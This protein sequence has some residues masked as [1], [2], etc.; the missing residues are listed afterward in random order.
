MVNIDGKRRRLI[1]QRGGMYGRSLICLRSSGIYINS[2]AA[3]VMDLDK[4]SNA[5]LESDDTKLWIVPNN[6]G[7]KLG[8]CR[9]RKQGLKGKNNGLQAR[10]IVCS[11][12]YSMYPS[13][14]ALLKSN[15][16]NL[17]RLPL[18][19]D[20][21]E[22]FIEIIPCF[23]NTV[24]TP[25]QLPNETGIYAYIDEDE[26]P[27][28]VYYGAAYGQTLNER[29]RQSSK[30]KKFTHISYAIISSDSVKKWEKFYIDK[31]KSIFGKNPKYNLRGG[32]H[33]ELI[34]EFYV[35]N[36]IPMIRNN[37][38]LLSSPKS[39]EK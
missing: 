23:L 18:Q 21:G 9:M 31:H 5:Y 17:S 29:C 19:K 35:K 37:I 13:L 22:F 16:K 30:D 33:T 1:P 2:I 6:D 14:G 25:M 4:F 38:A 12:I 32:D 28:V 34:D 10:D 36:K 26:N 3:E 11:W 27:E 39:G 24:E 7:A 15:D 20:N 8:N